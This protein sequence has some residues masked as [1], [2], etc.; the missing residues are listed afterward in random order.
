MLKRLSFLAFML[1]GCAAL[2]LAQEAPV[3]PNWTDITVQVLEAIAGV[4]VLSSG[5]VYVLRYLF[6]KYIPGAAIPYITPIIA[7]FVDVAAAYFTSGQWN[8]VIATSAGILAVWLHE[9]LLKYP[10]RRFVGRTSRK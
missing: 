2:A 3:P 4:A 8:P 5:V 10:A 9:A 6:E 7:Q 1:L